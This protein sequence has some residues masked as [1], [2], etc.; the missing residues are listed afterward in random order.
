ME[1]DLNYKEIYQKLQ[2]V[3]DDI[4]KHPKFRKRNFIAPTI[5]YCDDEIKVRTY[6]TNKAVVNQMVN[7]LDLQITDITTE[8]NKT[9]TYYK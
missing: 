2:K 1:T 9:N 6:F 5:Y 4:T 3:Y 7:D 8:Q